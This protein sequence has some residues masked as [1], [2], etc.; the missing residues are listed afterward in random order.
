MMSE[1][2]SMSEI[3][4]TAKTAAATRIEGLVRKRTLPL[5]IDVH[6]ASE[7]AAAKNGKLSSLPS[8]P[9]ALM[10]RIAS[11]GIAIRP[12]EKIAANKRDRANSDGASFIGI[13]DHRLSLVEKGESGCASVT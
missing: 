12:I 10:P 4:I 9:S 13:A 6:A 11:N 8:S 2:F 7:M 5:A 3:K 1:K